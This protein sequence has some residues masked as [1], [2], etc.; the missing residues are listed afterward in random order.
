[1]FLVP[2]QSGLAGEEGDPLIWWPGAIEDLVR[3]TDGEIESLARAVD[4]ER[5]KSGRAVISDAL[6]AEWRAFYN[7]WKAYR[8]DLGFGS[9]LTGATVTRTRVYRDRSHDWRNTLLNQG[10]TTVVGPAPPTPKSGYPWVKVVVILASIAVGA[11]A[12]SKVSDFGKLLKAKNP[13]RRNPLTA[14]G[15]KIKR[16]MIRHYGKAQGTRV[17]YA[18]ANAGRITGVVRK[19]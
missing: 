4:A 9:Y 1:M 16:A 10:T 8:E 17:F 2:A 5:Q 7:E 15:R 18:S 19:R 3:Q 13:R 14:K 11:Y 12:V 6:Y